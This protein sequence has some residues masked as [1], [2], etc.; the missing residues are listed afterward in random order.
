MGGQTLHGVNMTAGMKEA[1]IYPKEEELEVVDVVFDFSPGNVW[2]SPETCKV[3]SLLLGPGKYRAEVWGASGGHH[4]NVEASKGG[5]AKGEFTLEEPTR[6]FAVAGSVGE[7]AAGTSKAVRGGCNGGGSGFADS[8]STRFF[9]G[10]GGASHIAALVNDLSH[11]FLV[12]GG[13]GGTYYNL[14][15]ITGKGGEGGGE[16]GNDG[17]L[18]KPSYTYNGQGANQ[19]SPG[20]GCV[21]SSGCQAGAFGAGGSKSSKSSGGGGGWWGGASSNAGGIGA[22]GG[23]G[24]VFEGAKATGCPQIDQHPLIGKFPPLVN[25]ST[26]TGQNSGPGRVSISVLSNSKPAD[27]KKCSKCSNKY[28]TIQVMMFYSFVMS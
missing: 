6:L 5:Y 26:L 15:P 12:A 3:F 7:T 9:S 24:F 1:S 20:L 8:A 22:G 17:Y 14:E 18:G 23:S 28:F 16:R 27:L 2:T 11:R 21:K 4:Q 13:S 25:Q 10:G 19:T